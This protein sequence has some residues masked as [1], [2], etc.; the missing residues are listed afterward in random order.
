[1]IS[2]LGGSEIQIALVVVMLCFCWGLAAPLT[3]LT[4]SLVGYSDTHFILNVLTYS[5][6][7]IPPQV[8]S[9]SDCSFG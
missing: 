3:T 1:M 5:N 6:V 7:K 8:T 2:G 4:V 9:S